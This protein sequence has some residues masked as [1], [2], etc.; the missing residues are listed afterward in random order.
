VAHR[1]RA[2]AALAQEPSSIPSIHMAAHKLLHSR[3]TRPD[4]LC[5]FVDACIV[6]KYTHAVHTH[7]CEGTYLHIKINKYIITKLRGDEFFTICR[8]LYLL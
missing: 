8:L 5:W 4:T 1:L 3:I 7:L 2:L 6:L